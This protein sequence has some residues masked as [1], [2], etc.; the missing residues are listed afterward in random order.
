MAYNYSLLSSNNERLSKLEQR[1]Y[2]ALEQTDS[3]IFNFSRLPNLLNNAVAAGEQEIIKE[4]DATIADINSKLSAVKQLSEGEG[5]LA[6]S[7]KAWA[8][9]IST[10]YQNARDS[11]EKN[12]HR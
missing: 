2:P 12:N 5:D 8:E 7:A 10:Y 1:Y 11:S 3:I 6:V 4:A 9:S